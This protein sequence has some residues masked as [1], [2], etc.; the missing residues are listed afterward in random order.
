ML[1]KMLLLLALATFVLACHNDGQKSTDSIDAVVV[2]TVENFEEKAA[3]YVGL[4]VNISG[5]VDHTCKHSGKRMVIIGEDP[6]YS[7]KIEAGEVDQFNREL[8]GSDVSV[9]GVVTELRMD[10]NY[11]DDWE[12][13]IRSNHADDE[14]GGASELESVKQRREELAQSEKGYLS[15]YGMDCVNYTVLKEA[16]EG[17][18]EDNGP[19]QDHTEHSEGAETT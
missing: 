17:E 19:D 9:N 1:N 2:L 4:I 15:F 18:P 3:D 7:L 11:L 14:D 16:P 10:E 13:E 8:E 12:E 6:E 5:T